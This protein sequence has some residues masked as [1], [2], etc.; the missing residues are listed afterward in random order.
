MTDTETAAPAPK[1]KKPATPEQQAARKAS[2]FVARALAR[3]DGKPGDKEFKTRWASKKADY[4]TEAR[5]LV[6]ALTKE[7]V[8]LSVTEGAK[9]GKGGKGKKAAG[10]A[11]AS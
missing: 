6:R 3:A 9:K 11:A 8:A 2:R 5:K 4:T 1:P 7:G 10:E